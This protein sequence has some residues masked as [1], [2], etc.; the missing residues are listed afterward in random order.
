[1]S[2]KIGEIKSLED[3]KRMSDEELIH[4]AQVENDVIQNDCFNPLDILLREYAL[5]EL[6]RRGYRIREELVIEGGEEE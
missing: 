5:G 1:M 4:L 6:E 2:G 3:I